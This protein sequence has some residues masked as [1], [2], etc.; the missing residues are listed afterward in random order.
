MKNKYIVELLAKKRLTLAVMGFK[1]V[2]WLIAIR[3]K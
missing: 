1:D 2:V 3:R